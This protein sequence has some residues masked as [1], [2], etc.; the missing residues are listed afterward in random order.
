MPC[1]LGRRRHRAVNAMCERGR[2]DTVKIAR[3][4]H[5]GNDSVAQLA[6]AAELRHHVQGGD[7]DGEGRGRRVFLRAPAGRRRGGVYR[8]HLGLDVRVAGTV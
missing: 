3:A 4:E 2:P 6:N 8:D 1:G 7:D 5:C